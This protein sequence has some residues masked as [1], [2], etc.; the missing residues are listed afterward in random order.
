MML[1]FA[2]TVNPFTLVFPPASDLIDP[3]PAAASTSQLGPPAL[4]TPHYRSPIPLL[5]PS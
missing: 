4:A 1:Y 3:L 5:R 2:S